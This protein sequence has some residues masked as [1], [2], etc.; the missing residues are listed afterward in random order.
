MNVRSVSKS[1][2][3]VSKIYYF[4]LHANRLLFRILL[5]SAVSVSF[6]RSIFPFILELMFQLL[7]LLA[8]GSS[9]RNWGRPSTFTKELWQGEPVK[10]WLTFIS[11]HFIFNYYISCFCTEFV[12]ETC[13]NFLPL[14]ASEFKWPS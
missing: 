4:E 12:L 8:E 2:F 3:I 11:L 14:K 6:G 7:F 10:H 5:I 1:I 13:A 9:H